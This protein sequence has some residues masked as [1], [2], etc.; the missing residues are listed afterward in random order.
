MSIAKPVQ[1]GLCCLNTILRKQKP[2][3]FASRSIILR[4]LREKGVDNLKEKILE[5]LRDILKMMD[6]NEM[7]GIKVFRLS[8]GYIPS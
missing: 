8:S 4:T 3:V 6:W 2:P 5:N 1:L 7:N